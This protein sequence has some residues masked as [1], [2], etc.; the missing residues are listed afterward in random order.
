MDRG[1]PHGQ[2]HDPSTRPAAALREILTRV[3][4][5][6]GWGRVELSRVSQL[7]RF[8]G[9]YPVTLWCV[10]MVDHGQPQALK[11]FNFQSPPAQVE[12]SAF[13]LE[14]RAA[15]PY[16]ALTHSP[17]MDAWCIRMPRSKTRAVRSP[18]QP[19][20]R[21][22]KYQAHPTTYPRPRLPSAQRSA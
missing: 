20:F 13:R 4:P 9:S 14:R 16:Y 19:Y 8:S 7:L 1:I 22:S 21:T 3:P 5:W 18:M 15:P 6:A 11:A 17:A 10:N 12:A 2:R